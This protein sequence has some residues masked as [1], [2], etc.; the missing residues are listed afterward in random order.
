[1]PDCVSSV[2]APLFLFQAQGLGRFLEGVG[3]LYLDVVNA[4]GFKERGTH[5][6]GERGN[7]GA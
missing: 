7:Q 6:L 5:V 1:M 2:S 3:L 4:V